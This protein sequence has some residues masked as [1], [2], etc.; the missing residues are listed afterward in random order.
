MALGLG[1]NASFVLTLVTS[2]GLIGCASTP[3]PARETSDAASAAASHSVAVE[4]QT[5]RSGDAGPAR[6]SAPR[7]AP[8]TSST[9]N[10]RSPQFDKP[11]FTTFLRD[12]R[13]WVFQTTGPALADF[14]EA[15][16][17]AKC[18]TW[19]GAGPAGMSLRSDSP[20]V[21]LAY[22]GSRDHFRVF[23]KD[24]RLWVFTEGSESLRQ[25]LEGGEPAKCVTW[26]G[27]G[28]RDCTLRSDEADTLLA[29]VGAK[30]GFR[31]FGEDGR[32][33]VFRAESD[34]LQEYLE[35]GESAK[36][37]TWIGTGPRGCSLRAESAQTLLA[38]T[39]AKPGF[40]TFGTGENR[41]W[42]FR[43]GSEGLR[44]YVEEGE[45]G[46]C[47]T[48]IGAGPDGRTL[49][50]DSADTLLEYVAARPGFEVIAQD[51]RLWVFHAGSESLESFRTH[52]EPAKCVTFVGV[53]PRGA[54]VRSNDRSTILAYLN[55]I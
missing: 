28:P 16:E 39:S 14:R 23:P 30:D 24:G 12:G 46:K 35:S 31:T 6:G 7:H 2:T 25:F 41:I 9:L 4:S 22:L 19:V 54:T 40:Q 43:E 13:L 36:C 51:G 50:S 21:M 32:L 27:A 18:V 29:Y 44:H 5:P 47:I 26:V 17:P 3:D 15:G 49:R 55:A 37:V 52:G 11:G 33:W 45:P 20:D 8:A 53:G 1:P 48:W 42:V 38:Y 34:S 10:G